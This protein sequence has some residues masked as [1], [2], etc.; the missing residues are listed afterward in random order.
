MLVMAG[1]RSSK[2][3]IVLL[4]LTA[5]TLL[6]VGFLPLFGGPSY[7]FALACGLLLPLLGAP[8]NAADAAASGVLPERAYGVGLASGLRLCVVAW[9][10]ALFHG[11]RVGWCDAAADFAYFVVGPLPGA[12]LACTW[13]ALCGA[14]TRLRQRLWRGLVVAIPLSLLLPLL[15]IA[16]SFARYY[17]SPIIFAFDHFFGYFS[18]TPYDTIIEGTSRLLSYRAGTLGWLLLLFG[19]SAVAV[20]TAEG[21]LALQ[22]WERRRHAAVGL[23]GL[24]LGVGVMLSGTRLGHYQT[25]ASIRAELGHVAQS[26]RCEI[27]YATGISQ[28]DAHALARECDAHISQQERYFEI[29]GPAV[30]T[31]YLFNSSA[32]K[33]RLMGARDI[34]I[35]KPWRN[36][37]YLQV[38]H[39]PHP[40]LGHELAHVMAG[41]F[42]AGPFDIA[43]PAWG[44]IPDP[45]RIE[46][47]AVAASPPSGDDLTLLQW[48]RAMRDA[49]LLPPLSS[50]FRLG[51][52]AQ[53]SS[54]A[55]TIAGAFISWL[56]ETHGVA[57]VKGWYGGTPL[58]QLVDK[59]LVELEHDFHAHL[60]GIE[61][62]ARARAVAK[63]RFE[64]P[65]VFGRRCPHQVDRLIGEAHR[66]LSRFDPA[67][68]RQVFEDVLGMDPENFAAQAGLGVCAFREGNT[69][70]AE[71]I[72][73]RLLDAPNVSEPQR[74]WLA[75]ELGDL[76]FLAQDFD[77]ARAK[78]TLAK[79]KLV[80]QDRLR[81]LDV[82][83]VAAKQPASGQLS[84]RAVQSLLVGEP[85]FDSDWS[86]AA[87][88]L[89]RWAEADPN[90]GLAEYLIGRNLF[91]QGRWTAAAE[92]LDIALAQG[93]ALPSV[94]AEAL[95]TRLQL[96]CALGQLQIAAE[97]A[98][99]Y[100]AHALPSQARR[101]D[102][103]RLAERCGV[104]RETQAGATTGPGG[105]AAGNGSER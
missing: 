59:S 52:V 24:L 31:V 14:W 12:V 56:R 27:V 50:V 103:Q 51:F 28:R 19:V 75:E 36:E 89:G 45:G 84:R 10:V 81:S 101:R 41:R 65:A 80:D 18:G 38:N 3:Q 37:I 47:V 93:L 57:V 5:C 105:D 60:D 86:V 39:Y 62:S 42:G 46:G 76:A 7:E 92:A 40:I 68:A 34:Y 98:E 73:E 48:A 66:L 70:L 21:R 33:A 26:E 67:L 58:E 13:G 96:A 61:I 8:F 100:L 2:L 85:L 63:A 88:E 64:R 74:A 54:K 22:V 69:V 95:R 71:Q 11:L 20:R 78:Y 102:V 104:E 99:L 97:A 17:N 44:W 16:G 83:M 49:E 9:S 77:R 53:N 25:V 94:H 30:T 4:A 35:A 6:L 79:T 90:D 15:G 29:E 72:Y 32:Q 87:V 23:L 1:L 55:Y 91:S 82:K 43:G